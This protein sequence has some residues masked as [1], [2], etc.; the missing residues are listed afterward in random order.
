[1]FD[2]GFAE[3]ILLAGLGLIVLGPQRLPRAAAQL[4]RWVGQARRMS[5]T[6]M[7]QLRQEVNLDD[8]KPFAKTRPST[9]QGA[10]GGSGAKTGATGKQQKEKNDKPNR[11]LDKPK[12]ADSEE[13]EKDAGSQNQ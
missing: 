3:L 5:R 9:T 7:Y 4:G 1:M 11:N 12:K 6:L 13:P 2:I 10:G 8:P